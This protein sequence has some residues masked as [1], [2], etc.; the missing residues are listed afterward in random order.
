MPNNFDAIQLSL[1]A[2]ASTFKKTEAL[3]LSLD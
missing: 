3:A 2:Q 1:L